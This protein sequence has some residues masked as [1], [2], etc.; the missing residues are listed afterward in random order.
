MCALPG[1]RCSV[2]TLLVT[3]RTALQPPPPRR[4]LIVFLDGAAFVTVGED[5]TF[6]SISADETKTAFP[7][8]LAVFPAMISLLILRDDFVFSSC[9]SHAMGALH[10]CGNFVVEPCVKS[11]D[12]CSCTSLFFILQSKA[13]KIS[14]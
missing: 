13:G 2:E 7:W 8:I 3:A 1:R 5:I 12:K 6:P 4:D 9:F 10:D 14:T 11:E